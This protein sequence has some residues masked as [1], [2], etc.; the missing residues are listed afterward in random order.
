MHF[1]NKINYLFIEHLYK[2]YNIFYNQI[3]FM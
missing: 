3:I 1:N 2:Y